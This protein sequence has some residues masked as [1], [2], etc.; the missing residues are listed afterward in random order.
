MLLGKHSPVLHSQAV[1]N[2]SA[3]PAATELT[4]LIVDDEQDLRDLV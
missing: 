1:E 3:N 4:V 2:T